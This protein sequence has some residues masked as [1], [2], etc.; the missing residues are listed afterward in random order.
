ML[1]LIF[2]AAEHASKTPFYVAGGALVAWAVL[3][4]VLG[5]ARPAVTDGDVSHRVVMGGT[6]VL[7][8]L[9]MAMAVVASS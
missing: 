9:T 3:V 4:G 8:L 1:P 2:A 7:A 6:F 5:I